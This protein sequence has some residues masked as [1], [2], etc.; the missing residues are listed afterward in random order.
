MPLASRAT[1]SVPALGQT[2]DQYDIKTNYNVNSKL[3]I[4]GKYSDM[5]APLTGAGTLGELTGP[6]LGQ[7]GR[8]DVRVMIPGAGFN[9]TLSPTFL[10]DGVFGHTRFKNDAT[11]PNF[12]RNWGSEVWG[13]PGTNGGNVFA[14]DIR[15]SGQ[16]CINNGFTAWGNY[17]SSNPSFYEHGPQCLARS[18]L[19]QPIWPCSKISR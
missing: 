15:Y 12:G 18:R 2:R 10:I 11:G 13:I 7:L 5:N 3:M 8:A 19:S 14:D 4:W 1:T 6:A 16:P 17:S 9:V